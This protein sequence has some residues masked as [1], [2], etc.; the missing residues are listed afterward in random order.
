MKNRP[1][2]REIVAEIA[3][4]HDIATLSRIMDEANIPFSPVHTP[5][6][7]FTDPQALAHALPIN[8][9][10]GTTANLP[11]LPIA[12]DDETP[13]LRLQ[14]PASGE[15]TAAILAGLGY[16]SERIMGLRRSGAVS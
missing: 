11:S 14:P 1:A 15:H 3:L 8:M 12:F 5:S 6:D 13:G 4:S 2:L 16:A 7:L 10:N 9:P